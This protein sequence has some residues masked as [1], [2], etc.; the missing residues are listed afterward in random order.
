VGNL[1]IIGLTSQSHLS[2]CSRSCTDCEFIPAVLD[3][4]YARPLPMSKPA[5]DQSLLYLML[6]AQQ[7]A[8]QGSG[9]SGYAMMLVSIVTVM[10]LSLLTA[11][12]TISNIS[13]AA[14]NAY[15]E[16]NSTFYAAESGLNQRSDAVRQK[17]V[18]YA[19]PTG[20]SP[21]AVAG[22][23]AGPENIANCLD[24]DTT[25]DGS[26]DFACQTL[27]LNYQQSTGASGGKSADGKSDTV[28]S[29]N[30]KIKYNAYTF[31][32]DRTNYADPVNKIPQVQP[33]PSG[34]VYAGLSAQEY[35]YT[36]YSMATSKQST[37]LDARATTVLE[38]TFKNRVIPLFQFAAFYDGDLEMNSTS[39][40]NINGRVHTNG[41]FYSQPT[42]VKKSKGVALATTRLL[43]PLTA[44]GSIYNRVDSSSILRFGDTE[45]LISGDPNNPTAASNDYEYFPEYEPGRT[46]PLTAAEI[47]IF[48]GKVLDGAAGAAQLKVPLPGFLRKRDKDN[49]I[50]EYYGKADL[51]LEMVPK[52]AAGIVP[53]NFSAIKDGGSGESCSGFDVLTS[54][55]GA[56][57]KC[58]ALSEGQLRS[59]QQP[60]MVKVV[61]DE[62]RARFCPS[63]T[64]NYN[65]SSGGD[66]QTLRALQVAIAAQNTPT[67]FSQLSLPLDN[68]ANENINKIASGLQSSL[69]TGKSPVQLA[70]E[71]GGCFLPAPIQVLT[72]SGPANTNYN[73][74]SG[75]YERREQRW[76]GMLQTNLASL[77]V[78]NRDGLYVDRDNSFTTNDATTTSQNTAAFNSGSPSTTYDTNNLLFIR[79]AAKATAPTGSFQ[80]LGLGSVDTTEGGLV[81]HATVSDDFDG[82]GT[83]DITVD[84]ADNLRSYTD[85]KRKSSYGFA[86]TGGADL[87]GALT[88]VTDRGLFV[89]GDYNNFGGNPARQPASLVG[90]TITTLSNSCLDANT[91]RINCGILTGQN[92]ATATS[93][94]A[95]FLSFTNASDGN[96]G[97]DGFGVVQE[98]SGG[99]NNYMRMVENWAG[100]NFNYTG[101]FVSLGE[102]QEFSGDYQSGGSAGYYNVPNRNFGFDTNFNAF[103]KLP[104]L[105][106]KV[107]YLQQE[108]FKRSYR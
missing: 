25:N 36:I 28:T 77:T 75:Y 59:L 87:P 40:M 53:F 58:T 19:T 57:L 51:R 97:T 20:V 26:G 83:A 107:I 63:L 55:Q 60:V 44:A 12:L 69:D 72:G 35:R 48:K 93:M 32:S 9:E 39:Q 61:S 38:M 34:Q 8:K 89:Q 90:D 3:L 92:L 79:A 82:N 13:R 81:L 100:R 24:T 105:T 23:V 50:S 22:T 4:L 21:G 103:D 6:R 68:S 52:R 88:V 101:S 30:N 14:T 27:V 42:P 102:P 104:P 86:V 33:I 45:V 31:T 47:A 67:L 66:G 76:I 71:K 2:I 56:S 91:T 7:F 85:G 96:I 94:N 5:P 54:K 73:W 106:P 98:Y 16:S 46:S 41:N 37:D 78:W 18:G 108:T 95:A 74:Q 62:E 11:Y 49:Q 29:Y 15:T 10:M 80:K 70:A 65:P 1:G 43:A 99:L 84:S 17:F 64:N